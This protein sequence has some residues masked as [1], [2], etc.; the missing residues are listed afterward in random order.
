[1]DTKKWTNWIWGFYDIIGLTHTVPIYS[2]NS[3]Y[4]HF[5]RN[6]F[7]CY[8]TEK[9]NQ[10]ELDPGNS[11]IYIAFNYE[12]GVFYIIECESVDVYFREKMD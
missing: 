1:M 7:Y 10:K 12:M 9:L 11:Y 4:E 3:D 5:E 8:E 6:I 2:E